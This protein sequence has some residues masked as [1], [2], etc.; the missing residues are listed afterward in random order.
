MKLDVEYMEDKITSLG[1]EMVELE[2]RGAAEDEVARLKKQK[3]DLESRL[4]DQ[5]EEMDDLAGQVQQKIITIKM[6]YSLI[7][8]IVTN[9]STRYNS[10]R[11]AR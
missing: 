9:P 6:I 4:R 11:L 2:A 10:W 5:E 7:I 3:Q 8:F 1:K